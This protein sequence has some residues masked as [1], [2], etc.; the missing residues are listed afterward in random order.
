MLVDGLGVGDV[1][2]V[3]LRDRQHL[4]RDGVVI[5]QVSIERHSGKLVQEPE[6]ISR[7]FVYERESADLLQKAAEQVRN[8][9][10]RCRKQGQTDFGAVRTEIRDT[11][12]KFLYDRTGRQPM[13]LPLL[14][15]V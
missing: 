4:A 11:L 5:A 15:E 1:G 10:A 6:V 12:A 2:A 14:V 3:V 7:G 9:V 13:V 8:A